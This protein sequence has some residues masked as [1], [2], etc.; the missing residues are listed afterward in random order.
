M[1][2]K[3]LVVLMTISLL[4]GIAFLSTLFPPLSIENFSLLIL[5]LAI[6]G[7]CG[8]TLANMSDKQ[9]RFNAG[10]KRSKE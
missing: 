9:K 10:K 6:G 4:V 7:A 3:I 2:Q 1:F 8:V 5:A